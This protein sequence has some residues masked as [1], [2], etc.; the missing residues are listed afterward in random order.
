MLETL[1]DKVA[2]PRACNFIEQRLLHRCFPLKFCEIFK[3]TFFHRTPPVI[4]S[5]LL[6]SLHLIIYMLNL[7]K[8]FLLVLTKFLFLQGARHWAII[9]LGLDTFLI[10]HS[11]LRSYV[12]SRSATRDVTRIYHVY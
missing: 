11:F 9:L 12:L 6:S 4:A 2:G 8:K 10:F 5:G 7:L 1:F 3:E